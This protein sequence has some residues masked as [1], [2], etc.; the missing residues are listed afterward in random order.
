MIEDF[1]KELGSITNNYTRTFGSLFTAIFNF[2]RMIALFFL[3][4]SKLP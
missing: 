4:E 1:F 2:S 3:P